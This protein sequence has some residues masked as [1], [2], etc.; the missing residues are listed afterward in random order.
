MEYWNGGMVGLRGFWSFFFYIIP[1]L[2]HSIIPARGK[3]PS[4]TKA[5]TFNKL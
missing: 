5:Y 2:H 3:D 1:I 4:F